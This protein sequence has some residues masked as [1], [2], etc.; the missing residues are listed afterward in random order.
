MQQSNLCFAQPSLY[1]LKQ[2]SR[3]TIRF[4]AQWYLIQ[5]P[6]KKKKVNDLDHWLCVSQCKSSGWYEPQIGFNSKKVLSTNLIYVGYE[7]KLPFFTGNQ[8]RPKNYEPGNGTGFSGPLL[9]C[10][11]RCKIWHHTTVPPT[12]P[13]Q[14]TLCTLCT[15]D[16]E[17]HRLDITA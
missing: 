6:K 13:P 2:I 11:W 14:V 1:L 8:Q 9:G 16:I 10:C 3:P 17:G 4:Q 5:R 12:P 7:L 15:L